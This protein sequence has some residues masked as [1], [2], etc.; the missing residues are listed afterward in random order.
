MRPVRPHVV[1]RSCPATVAKPKLRTDAPFAWASLSITT[2]RNLRRAAARAVARP[3]MPAPTTARSNRATTYVRLT[4]PTVRLTSPTPLLEP[5]TLTRELF[6]H[7]GD[8]EL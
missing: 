7:R 1:P 8:L 3:R 5:S 6:L 4:S 2:T